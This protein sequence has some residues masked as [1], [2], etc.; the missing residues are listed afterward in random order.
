VLGDE[1]RLRRLHHGCVGGVSGTGFGWCLPDHFLI[2][3][4]VDGNES[5]YIINSKLTV[6]GSKA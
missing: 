6:R 1:Q 3:H 4:F 5:K 2:G